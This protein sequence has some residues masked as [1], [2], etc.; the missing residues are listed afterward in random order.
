MGGLEKD[1]K[2]LRAF[3]PGML[4]QNPFTGRAA[5]CVKLLLAQRKARIHL[6]RRSYDETFVTRRKEVGKPSPIIGQNDGLADGRLKQANARRIASVHHRSVGQIQGRAAMGI[7]TGV[8]GWR[9]ML[10]VFDVAGP[11]N[12]CGILSARDDKA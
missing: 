1:D 4:S 11:S 5:D 8:V 7:K 2:L 3:S 12:C 9:N 6:I 10:A